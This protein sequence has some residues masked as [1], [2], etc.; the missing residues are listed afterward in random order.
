VT[1]VDEPAKLAPSA[2][3]MASGSPLVGW[4]D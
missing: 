2:S 3:A 1:I 4:G